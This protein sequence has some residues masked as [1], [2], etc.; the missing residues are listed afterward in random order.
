M[1]ASGSANLNPQPPAPRTPSRKSWGGRLFFATIAFVVLSALSHFSPPLRRLLG[2]IPYLFPPEAAGTVT[3]TGGTGDWTMHVDECESGERTQYFGIAF[4]DHTQRAL[5][6]HINL[7]EDETPLLSI[8]TPRQ[9]GS[10]EI[11]SPGCSVWDVDLRRTN[12]TYNNI[13]AMDGHA[14]FDCQYH[15]PEARVTGDLQFRSCH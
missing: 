3:S 1:D 7:R 6:G 5:G 8:N 15:D 14:R 4:F 13:W 11:R 9:G 10:E 12:S 2:H